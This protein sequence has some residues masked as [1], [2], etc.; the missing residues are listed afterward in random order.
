M[1]VEETRPS[2]SLNLGARPDTV[3]RASRS[4]PCRCSRDRAPS[5]PTRPV[6]ID[7]DAITFLD[8]AA[9]SFI[10]DGRRRAGRRRR[11]PTPP[12]RVTTARFNGGPVTGILAEEEAAM[13]VPDD[14]IVELASEP[15]P[16]E[17]PAPEALS[18]RE[19]AT[20]ERSRAERCR[21]MAERELA[22]AAQEGRLQPLH[23]AVAQMHADA[24]HVHER[25]ARRLE[26]Q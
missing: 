4:W 18:P 8:S 22:A 5:G 11:R 1:C 17:A 26:T 16:V 3:T 20:I 12:R 9:L 2:R 15:S 7:L 19:L 24:A 21:G 23:R 25:M 13:A 14:D 10:V 6:T